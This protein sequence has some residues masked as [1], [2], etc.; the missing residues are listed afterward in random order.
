[1]TEVKSK[2]IDLIFFSPPY[3]IKTTYGNYKDGLTE[4]NT[5]PF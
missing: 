1:M 3:N 4:K 2:A 5:L